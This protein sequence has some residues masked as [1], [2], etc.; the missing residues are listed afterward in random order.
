[1]CVA[2][3]CD[4]SGVEMQQPARAP[5]GSPDH[6]ARF[7][8]A[9]PRHFVLPAVL[10][11]LSEEPSY[12][13]QLV[14]GLRAFR[15]GDVD[16]PAVYR[17]L[18]LLEKDGLVESWSAESKAGQARRVYDVTTDGRRALRIWMGVVKEERDGLDRVLRRYRATG[19]AD[20][21]LAEA[22]A[23][24][25]LV[26]ES[27]LEPRLEPTQPSTATQ[28]VPAARTTLPSAAEGPDARRDVALEGA[29]RFSLIP[30]ESAVLIEARSTVGPITFGTLGITGF[31]ECPII[32]GELR[33]EVSTCARLVVALN[34]LR[35]GNGLYD[36]E[37]LRRIDARRFPTATLELLSCIPIGD[38]GRYRLDGQI[39]L[40]GATRPLHG[41]VRAALT[42]SGGI[43]VTGEQ[44]FDIRD[45]DIAIPTLLMLRI[46]PDVTVRLQIEAA[47][48]T[49][50]EESS[51]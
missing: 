36:A 42:S 18:A 15:F 21:L 12:G 31:V 27:A 45:F 41:T 29:A 44:D 26:G 48:D 1:V 5:S 23:T 8:F 9:P 16:R 28:P 25:G 3:Y 35:S 24:L 38:G 13:Y 11:L 47:I 46:Y 2:P 14:K 39:D 4:R 32:D 17:A 51:P 19:T 22:E 33:P 7:T 40:H 50:R 20:A 30:E 10:L 43:S 37:L 6:L 34:E 49:H